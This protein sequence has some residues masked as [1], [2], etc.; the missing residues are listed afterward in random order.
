[1]NSQSA[2]ATSAP[3][4]Y[5]P[6][7]SPS[8]ATSA[9]TTSSFT[10]KNVALP[11]NRTSNQSVEQAFAPFANKMVEAGLPAAAIRMFRHYYTQLYRGETGFIDCQ[12]AQPVESLPTVAE[13]SSYADAGKA[14][15]AQTAVIKLNGGLGT[16]MGMEGPKS[17][18]TVKEGLSFLD[19]IVRQI[20]YLRQSHEVDLPLILM[21]SF[22]T[23]QASAEAL[24][25]YPDLTQ[26]V[27]YDFMQHRIPKIWQDD[28]GAVSWSENRQLEWC[29]PGH[30]DLYLALQTSGMLQQLLTAGYTYAFIS[31]ADNLGATVDLDI[32]GYFAAN[33]VPFLMEVAKRTAADRKGG[34]LAQN[35]E[36]GLI[37][38]EVAQCPPEEMEDFQNIKRYAYFNTNN[39]WVHLPTLQT[40]LQE[41]EGVLDLPLI[42][43]KKPVDP[44]DPESPGVYQLETAM[45][46]AIALFPNAQALQIE[47]N[48]FLPVKST[49]DLLALWSDAYVLDADYQI[50]L[51]PERPSE[52][53]P[54]V[55]LD[56]R[57]YGLFAD[58][59]ARFPHGAPSLVNCA[60]F[61]V[62]GDI[63]FDADVVFTGEIHISHPH[64]QPLH[65]V[66]EPT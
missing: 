1:M 21:N 43:N 52:E 32:L 2:F 50:R 15:L 26:A 19:I 25:H 23:Q 46:H 13:L 66:S 36:Q 18:I 5:A 29:P 48:R 22:N 9:A 55:E 54:T 17:L 56:K 44:T 59:Q 41:Q 63:C 40:L 28:L 62:E 49:N 61:T 51:N 3:A 38:R 6:V 53:P 45:G 33:K 35:A 57:F 58:L 27:P 20:L 47:R 31:N 24:A 37:L 39:L 7:N 12:A 14:A 16:T 42:R 60:C 4:N 10:N 64:A 34:H 11:Q 65:W 8:Q 30:G